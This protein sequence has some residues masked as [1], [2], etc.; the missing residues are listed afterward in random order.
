MSTPGDVAILQFGSDDK[1]HYAFLTPSQLSTLTFNTGAGTAALTSVGSATGNLPN[2]PIPLSCMDLVTVAPIVFDPTAKTITVSAATGSAAGSMSGA[3]KGRLD[4]IFAGTTLQYVRG[5]GSLATLATVATSGAYSSLSGL[6]T[7][8][9]AAATNSTAYDAS[10]AAASAQAASQ[11]LDSDLT[12]IAA[13]STTSFGRALLTAANAASILSTLGTV[14]ISFD[15]GWTANSTV[16]DKT[17][18]LA[19]YSNGLN[20]TM[21]TALNLVSGGTGTAISAAF[22][23]LVNVVKQLAATRTALIAAKLPNV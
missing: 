10:G 3:D 18:S 14:A 21:I 6:P 20:G 1:W 17:A 9:T 4:S 22:D 13:L 19:S 12:A 8:G 7:L 15:T 5:D 11:P 23:V 16:G 2:V